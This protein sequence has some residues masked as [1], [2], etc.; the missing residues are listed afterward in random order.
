MRGTE[1]AMARRANGGGGIGSD[2]GTTAAGGRP[3][4]VC[5]SAYQSGPP[6]ETLDPP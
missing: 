2:S 6:G 4:G 3:G 1:A 5:P